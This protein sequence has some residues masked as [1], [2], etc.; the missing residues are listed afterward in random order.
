V[1]LEAHSLFLFEKIKIFFEQLKFLFSF[2]KFMDGPKVT[3]SQ[4]I[5]D[6]EKL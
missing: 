5:F 2:L 6:F 1:I 4:I 3:S